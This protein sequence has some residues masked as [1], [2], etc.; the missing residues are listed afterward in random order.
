MVF[1]FLN[2]FSLCGKTFWHKKHAQSNPHAFENVDFLRKKL[3]KHSTYHNVVVQQ[4]VQY[5][6]RAFF[7]RIWPIAILYISHTTCEYEKCIS[8]TNCMRRSRDS[9]HI[10]DALNYVNKSNAAKRKR[11]RQRERNWLLGNFVLMEIAELP[12]SINQESM[13][14]M[15]Q[16]EYTGMYSICLHTFLQ[17][18]YDILHINNNHYSYLPY[19]NKTIT[20]MHQANNI[21]YTCWFMISAHIFNSFG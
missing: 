14:A 1:C 6:L 18:N 13:S 3:C 5:T 11:K 12:Q 7:L 20:K 19:I 8:F 15:C 9:W 10:L 4:R 16:C 17:L 21:V 2:C